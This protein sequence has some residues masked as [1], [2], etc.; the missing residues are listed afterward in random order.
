M[1]AMM[2]GCLFI[3]ESKQI[4]Y[5]TPR[6]GTGLVISPSMVGYLKLNADPLKILL[7][8][9]HIH[10]RLLAFMYLIVGRIKEVF[11]PVYPKS[12][13]FPPI[14]MEAK[15]GHKAVRSGPGAKSGPKQN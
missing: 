13:G 12:T 9:F 10:S 2:E 15:P 6:L 11:Q 5:T 8:Q 4:M 3:N 7:L 1:D 14:T